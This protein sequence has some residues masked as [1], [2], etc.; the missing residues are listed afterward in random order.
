MG[1]RRWIGRERAH[2]HAQCRLGLI[3]SPSELLE[4]RCMRGLTREIATLLRITRHVKQ[5]IGIGH[6]ATLRQAALG[7]CRSTRCSV[8][9]L[10]RDQTPPPAPV[11]A[12][13]NEP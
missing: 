8:R 4:G 1:A 3:Q 13:C 6:G 11:G 10:C 9:V 12:L 5:L 2:G 7:I